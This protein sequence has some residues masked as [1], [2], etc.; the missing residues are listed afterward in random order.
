MG[1]NDGLTVNMQLTE[2][3][4]KT[5]HL[6]QTPPVN[7]NEWAIYGW[8]CYFWMNVQFMDESAIYG[9]ILFLDKCATFGKIVH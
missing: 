8:M 4:V 7:S 2:E 5:V 9:R 3:I 1:C 6:P